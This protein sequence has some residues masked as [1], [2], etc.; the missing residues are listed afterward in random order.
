MQHGMSAGAKAGITLAALAA[1]CCLVVAPVMVLKRRKKQQRLAQQESRLKL[2]D[3][4]TVHS[5]P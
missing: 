5:F 1:F 2:V 3:P 4:Q